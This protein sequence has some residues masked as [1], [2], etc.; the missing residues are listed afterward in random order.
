MPLTS[1]YPYHP[2]SGYFHKLFPE[3]V[4]MSLM[5]L[6][7]SD[8]INPM[9][10]NDYCFRIQLIESILSSNSALTIY[11]L[12]CIVDLSGE[13]VTVVSSNER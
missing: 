12:S 9:K 7:A 11:S 10:V 4:V 2:K 1:S 13:C 3:G 8:I 6:V 5:K